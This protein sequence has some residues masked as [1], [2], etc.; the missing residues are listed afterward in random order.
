MMGEAVL[1]RGLAIPADDRQARI[2]VFPGER[3]PLVR[4]KLARSP[5]LRAEIERQNWHFLKWEHA[6]ALLARESVSLETLEPV[7]G[8]DPLIERG[9]DQLTMF[10]E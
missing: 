5:W 4:L 6:D 10:G 1:R 7:L 3:T 8:L 2:L 9:G